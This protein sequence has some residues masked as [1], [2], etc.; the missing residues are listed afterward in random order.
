MK[1]ETINLIILMNFLISPVYLAMFVENKYVKMLGVLWAFM[2]SIYMWNDFDNFQNKENKKMSKEF[3][4]I[5]QGEKI[6]KQ[7]K[8]I[9]DYMG[10]EKR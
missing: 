8:R 10:M 7:L 9:A 5:E 4:L 6:N 2:I 1:I 3:D